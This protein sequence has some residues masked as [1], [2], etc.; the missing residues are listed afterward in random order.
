MPKQIQPKFV[1]DVEKSELC[2]QAGLQDRVVQVSDLSQLPYSMKKLDGL[3]VYEG[4]VCMDFSENV[5]KQGYGKLYLYIVMH[6]GQNLHTTYTC[7]VHV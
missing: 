6:I 4:L 5:M 1:L 3:Q 2:I 7:R